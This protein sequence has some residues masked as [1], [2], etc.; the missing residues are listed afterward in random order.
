MY[1]KQVEKYNM[2]KEQNWA[3]QDICRTYIHKLLEKPEH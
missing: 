1:N 2:I 3:F